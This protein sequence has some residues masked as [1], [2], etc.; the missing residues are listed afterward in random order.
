MTASP[1]TAADFEL[2][3]KSVLFGED[4][5]S[6]LRVSLDVVRDRVEAIL[7]VWYGFVGANPHLLASFGSKRDGKPIPEYLDGVRKRFG[8]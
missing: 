5:V 3:K 2:M 4:D 1:V 6:W 8:Q 7:D